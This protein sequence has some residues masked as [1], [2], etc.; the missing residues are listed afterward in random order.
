MKLEDLRKEID[1]I[2]EKI[3]LLLKERFKLVRKIGKIKKSK[4]MKI[5][6]PKR[7]R[8]ILMKIARKARKYRIDPKE[9]I[10]IYK[11]ILKASR[12]IQQNLE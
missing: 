6:Q 2:D 4:S 7:E 11:A 5:Y 12:K 10:K 8:E 9:I 1:K 3:F